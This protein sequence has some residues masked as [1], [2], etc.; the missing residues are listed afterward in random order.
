MDIK[1]GILKLRKTSGK[2]KDFG[3]SF[4][5]IRANAFHNYMT[6]LVSLFGKKAPNF[7]ATLAEF[8]SFIYKLSLIFNLQE[9]VISM[10]IEVHIFIIAQQSTNPLK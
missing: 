3:K 10:V 8:Y 7:Y 5:E 6:I 9:T 1:D 4:Y 2:Y